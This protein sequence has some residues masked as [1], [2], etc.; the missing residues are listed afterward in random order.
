MFEIPTAVLSYLEMFLNLLTQ[1]AEQLDNK[2]WTVFSIQ[3]SEQAI[4]R[5][6]KTEDKSTS[7]KATN[8]ALRGIHSKF[9]GSSTKIQGITR[10]V[11][12]GFSERVYT[13]IDKA[14]RYNN[15]GSRMKTQPLQLRM[16]GWSLL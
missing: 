1:I 3:L 2:I 9:K 15:T 5:S 16:A 11:P 13:Y 8:E 6:S 10:E 4:N 14:V 7:T 12:R